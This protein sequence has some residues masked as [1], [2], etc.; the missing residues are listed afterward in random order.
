[1]WAQ[2]LIQLQRVDA[3]AVATGVYMLQAAC[4]VAA[5]AS[6]PA[7]LSAAAVAAAV[8]VAQR[9]LLSLTETGATVAPL[10]GTHPAVIDLNLARIVNEKVFPWEMSSRR[11]FATAAQ[12]TPHTRV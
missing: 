1:M 12:S 7:E 10:P 9:S 3:G 11:R 6:A 2:V 5:V 8:A 4:A